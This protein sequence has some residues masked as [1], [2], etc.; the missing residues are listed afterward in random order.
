MQHG[1]HGGVGVGGTPPQRRGGAVLLRLVIATAL[2]L[3]GAHKPHPPSSK[4]LKNTEN[5]KQ[6]LRQRKVTLRECLWSFSMQKTA[7]LASFE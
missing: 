5:N 2:A 4:T 1:V 6:R 3:L 7:S